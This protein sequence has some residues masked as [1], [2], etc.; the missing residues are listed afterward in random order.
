M[1]LEPILTA[2]SHDSE[3]L[4]AL[5]ATRG[6]IR[7]ESSDNRFIMTR[8]AALQPGYGNSM[9]WGFK[10]NPSNADEKGKFIK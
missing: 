1:A 7:K 5:T 3:P 8:K 2:N 4:S 6:E 10:Q 9:C